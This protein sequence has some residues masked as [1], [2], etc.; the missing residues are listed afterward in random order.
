MA[1]LA[2]ADEPGSAEVSAAL[3]LNLVGR[4]A[5]LLTFAATWMQ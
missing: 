3:L 5:C 2:L 4:K 1:R